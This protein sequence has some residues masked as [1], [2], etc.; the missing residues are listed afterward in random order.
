VA[1]ELGLTRDQAQARL[2]QARGKLFEARSTRI[3]PGLDDKLLTAWNALMIGGL[4]RSARAMQAPA[5]LA[6]AETALDYMWRN[7]WR[8]GRLQAKAGADSARFPGYL[9]DN[10]FLLD[11]LLECLQCRW[12]KRDID[13][14]VQLA[15]ALLARF[16]DNGGQGGFFFTAHDHERLIQRSK[17]WTDDATPSGNGIAARAL[18]RLGHLL[19]ETRYVDAAERTLRAAFS[20]MQQMPLACASLQRA[21]NDFLHPRTHV[22]IRHADV[23][24]SNAWQASLQGMSMR[25]IDI[26]LIAADAA[27]LPAILRAQTHASGGVAYVCRGSQCLPPLRD[28]SAL[29]SYLA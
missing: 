19:G 7:V 26:Y 5:L 2:V 24:E 1:R 16:E 13:W 10:A 6:H 8:D 28:A 29:G 15:D 17:P 27:D 12:S 9:D 23:Q 20:T 14:A 4:A 3:P 18:L 22:V 25:R 21:L 11:A